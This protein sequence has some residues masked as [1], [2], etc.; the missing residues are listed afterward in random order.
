MIERVAVAW[1]GVD[2]LVPNA[3]TPYAIKPFQD[4]TW[5]EALA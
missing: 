1:G 5:E 3:L 2:V 4:M